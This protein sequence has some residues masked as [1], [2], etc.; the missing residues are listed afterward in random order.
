MTSHNNTQGTDDLE[1]RAFV[2]GQILCSQTLRAGLNETL[3]PKHVTKEEL[4]NLEK[5][6]MIKFCV[7]GGH[8]Y[9]S[10]TE[11]GISE[12]F[13]GAISSREL[14]DYASRED[15]DDLSTLLEDLQIKEHN[16]EEKEDTSDFHYSE[17]ISMRRISDWV[18]Q[19][20]SLSQEH[21]PRDLVSRTRYPIY[22]SGGTFICMIRSKEKDF[23]GRDPSALYAQDQTASQIWDWICEHLP[24]TV[25]V[26]TTSKSEKEDKADSLLHHSDHHHHQ[27][28]HF[29]ADVFWKSYLKWSE[30]DRLYLL[31]VYELFH[32][33]ESLTLEELDQDPVCCRSEQN[34]RCCD[35]LKQSG[36]IEIVQKKED[37]NRYKLILPRVDLLEFTRQKTRLTAIE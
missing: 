37:T 15:D 9:C 33:N 1:R 14:E 2:L 25:V 3:I 7:T 13:R 35:L 17:G 23:I 27:S 21:F 11:S 20:L 12:S 5:R 32:P 30:D 31:D 4:F 19:N 10:V 36:L 22:R 8:R 29:D 6:S 26:S 16:D 28:S 18:K 34:Q 24:T